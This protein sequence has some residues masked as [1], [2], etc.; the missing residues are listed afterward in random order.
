M[1]KR[2]YYLS[3]NGR[4]INIIADAAAVCITTSYV[5]IRRTKNVFIFDFG[6]GEEWKIRI[7]RLCDRSQKQQKPLDVLETRE[8]TNLAQNIVKQQRHCNGKDEF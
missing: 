5:E 7:P 4:V 1:R 2:S 8:F 3:H 6:G